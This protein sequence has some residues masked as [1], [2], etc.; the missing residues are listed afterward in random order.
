MAYNY[1][2]PRVSIATTRNNPGPCYALPSLLGYVEHDPRSKHNRGPAYT[3]GRRDKA[4][5]NRFI[6]PGPGRYYV[7]TDGKRG[8]PHFSIKGRTREP[9]FFQTPGPGTN[10]PEKSDQIIRCRASAYSFGSRYNDKTTDNTPGPNRYLLPDTFGKTVESNRP[11]APSYSVKSRT[12]N[13]GFSDELQNSPGPAA[14][15]A[16]DT[17]HYRSRPHGHTMSGRYRVPA[18]MTKTPG[19]GSHEFEK[20]WL[21]KHQSP[22]VS[23][24]IRHSAYAVPL[25]LMPFH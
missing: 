9:V 21:H 6:G 25:M 4:S 24:G 16:V 3:F 14:Y 5:E 19:P 13:D 20:V 18:D 10:Q 17:R 23:F 7:Q 11:Q 15:G 8:A 12:K 1:T 22:R 2:K